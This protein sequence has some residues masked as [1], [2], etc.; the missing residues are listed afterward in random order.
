M[1]AGHLLRHH[2]GEASE[3]LDDH[4]AADLDFDPPPEILQALA[5]R[6]G[7]DLGEVRMTTIAGW[8]PWLA[9]TLDPYDGQEAS[10]LRPAGLGAPGPGR[11]RRQLGPALGALDTG[12]R[13]GM[14]DRVPGLSERARPTRT[15]APACSPRCLS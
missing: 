7:I 6:T 3:L 11:G 5:E 2:L 10:T 9:D 12:A 15:G 4:Q 13:Q 1:P 14:A 8:V